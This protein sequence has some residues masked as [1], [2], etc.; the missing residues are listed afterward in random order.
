MLSGSVQFLSERRELL[1]RGWRVL[2]ESD[3]AAMVKL[4]GWRWLQ[5]RQR[6]G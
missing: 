3:N 6:T 5:R 4:T 1:G 2:E